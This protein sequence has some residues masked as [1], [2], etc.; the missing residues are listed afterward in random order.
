MRK[1]ICIFL[2]ASLAAGMALSA[3]ATVT[4]PSD[5]RPGK[6][7]SLFTEKAVGEFSL[8]KNYGKKVDVSALFADKPGQNTEAQIES[9]KMQIKELK[10][11]RLYSY[12]GIGGLVG[13]AAFF[14]YKF[15]THEP[16]E[17]VTQEG[18]TGTRGKTTGGKAFFIGGGLL[19]L[20]ISVMLFNNTAKYGKTIK[21]YEAEIEKLNK[22]KQSLERQESR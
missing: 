22:L 6:K 7:A 3:A 21:A 19:C 15:A 17:R 1:T 12:L 18:A 11:K 13:L 4:D 2:S 20:G 8:W 10:N 9:L 14:V 5:L 16:G